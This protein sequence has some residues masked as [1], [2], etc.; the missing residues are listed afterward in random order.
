MLGGIKTSEFFGQ[1]KVRALSCLAGS[2]FALEKQ[3]KIRRTKIV[4]TTFDGYIY[5]SIFEPN[6]K[7]APNPIN[8]SF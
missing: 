5:I 2:D 8:T 6:Y 3:L 7:R 4:S 1:P